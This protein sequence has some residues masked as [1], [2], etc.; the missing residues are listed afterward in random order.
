MNVILGPIITEKS[1]KDANLGKFTFKVVKTADK[2]QIKNAVEGKFKVNVQDVATIIVK[3][4]HKTSFQRHK[5]IV[6]SWKKAIVKL[7][8]DQKIAMFDLGAKK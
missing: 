2:T 3:P 6:P 5:V 4:K 8:K 1:M 7:L